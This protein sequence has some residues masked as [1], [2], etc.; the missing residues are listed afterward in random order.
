MNIFFQTTNCEDCNASL[1][2]TDNADGM[3]VDMMEDVDMYGGNHACTACGKQV[4]HSC[5][6]SNMGAD[7][8]CSQ[9]AGR[10]AWVGEMD[11][12]IRIRRAAYD[13]IKQLVYQLH[14][15]RRY[16]GLVKVTGER[17]WEL[18]DCNIHN[19][20]FSDCAFSMAHS[21]LDPSSWF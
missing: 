8:R 13:E 17:I 3:D 1:N 20:R 18:S 4:C 15:R 7:K 11:G 5:S 10:T 6:V 9:C 19:N 16:S 14:G 12:A 2:P 21:T